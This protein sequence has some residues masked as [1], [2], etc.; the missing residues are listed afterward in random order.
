MRPL[1]SMRMRLRETGLYA[2][3]GGTAADWELEAYAAGLELLYAA[4]VELAQ[5][6][7]P[8]TAAAEG[9]SLWEGLF[10]L[11]GEG[12]PEEERRR[13]LLLRVSAVPGSREGLLRAAESMGV[14][15][16]AAEE[17]GRICCMT[18]GTPDGEELSRFRR[19][20][21]GFVPAHL[22][23]ILDS[24]PLSWDAVEEK[25]YSWQ[26]MDSASMTWR[27]IDSLGGGMEEI[28]AK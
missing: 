24:R 16:S 7:F 15:V 18:A 2:L 27:D 17:P 25:G 9:L 23:L 1:E 19:S 6:A 8:E 4:V 3:S 20:I 26:Q 12:L 28:P 13:R 10:G 11:S 5:N 22:K 21:G 14:P